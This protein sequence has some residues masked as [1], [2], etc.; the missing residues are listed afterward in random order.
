MTKLNEIYE[1]WHVTL[2]NRSNDVLKKDQKAT[3]FVIYVDH[4]LY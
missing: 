3:L 2:C 4:L 1:N